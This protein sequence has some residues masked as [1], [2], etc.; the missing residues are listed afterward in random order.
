MTSRASEL[1]YATDHKVAITNVWAHSGG[2][3][4]GGGASTGSASLILPRLRPLNVT[5]CTVIPSSLAICFPE[6]VLDSADTLYLDA[7]RPHP[8]YFLSAMNF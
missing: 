5:G 4:G 8:L 1:P 7:A 3:G 2:G 6:D